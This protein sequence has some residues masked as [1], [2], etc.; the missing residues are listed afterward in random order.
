[1]SE[2]RPP[3]A[4]RSHGPMRG[5][6]PGEKAKDFKGTI[7]KLARYISRYKVSLIVVI[8]FAILSTVFSIIGPKI[9]GNAIQEIYVGL[10][11][12]VTHNGLGMNYDAIAKILL[13]LLALYAASAAF[14]YIQGYLMSGVSNKISYQLR[15]EIESK[16]HKLPIGYY[17]KKSHGDVLSHITNDVDTI[18]NNLNSSIT[19]II[20]SITTV[21]GILYMMFSISWQ[22]SLVALIVLPVSMIFIMQVVKVS[23]KYF[24]AQ[25]NYLGD[26]NGHIEEMYGAHLIVKAYNGEEKSTQEFEQLNGKLYNAGWKS[27]FMSG[28]MMPIM[29]FIGNIGYVVVCVLGGYYAS[30]GVITVGN[31]QSFIT[32]MKNFTQPLTQVANISNIF[33]QVAAASERVFEFLDSEEEEPDTE[34]PLPVDDIKGQVIF[35]HVKFGYNP[36]KIVINDFTAVVEPGQKVAIVGPTGAG[37]TTVIKLLMRFYDLNEGAICIDGLDLKQFTRNDLRSLFGMV[38]QDTWSYNASI[39]ENIRYGK[40]DATDEEVIAAAKLAQADHFIK[41]LPNGYDMILNEEASNISQGQKQLLTIARAVLT[42]PKILILDEATS[43]VDTR[44]EILIQ[45]A[46]DN[47]MVGRTSF[48]IAHRLSTIKNADMILCMDHGDI[49]EKGTHEELLAKG[50]FYAKLYNSQF[51]EGEEE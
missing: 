23:Q 43:S 33:Q 26:V 6:M 7:K 40:P 51:E 42:D 5:M 47:L 24:T 22:M 35:A 17:D 1:M 39:K 9:M 38:L 25:Q 2:K 32:Y 13:S 3:R 30:Q 28:L 37:K 36:D 10:M 16:I 34:Y 50:G 31:I 12:I 41:T 29:S 11:N 48:I 21:I 18:S 44:T 4:N 19:Q 14:S 20:T 46:M 15:K 27:Q 49:V 45:K 8:V